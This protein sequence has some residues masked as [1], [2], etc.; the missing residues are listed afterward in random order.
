MAMANGF[1]NLILLLCILIPILFLSP[2]SQTETRTPT[3]GYCLDLIAP[4][5]RNRAHSL[6]FR[7]QF[8]SLDQF[9]VRLGDQI[10]RADFFD[11][12]DFVVKLSELFFFLEH[13]FK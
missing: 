12:G 1:E 8:F 7:L 4:P 13:V 2:S 3:S 6:I 5:L 11:R 9:L 10:L